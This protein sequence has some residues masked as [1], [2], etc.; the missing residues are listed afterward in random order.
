MFLLRGGSRHQHICDRPRGPVHPPTPP[1]RNSR[2]DAVIVVPKLVDTPFL[3]RI[4]PVRRIGLSSNFMV[5]CKCRCDFSAVPYFKAKGIETKYVAIW[6]AELAMRHRDESSSHSVLRAACGWGL[7]Q[8]YGCLDTR[9]RYFDPE[10]LAR[11]QSGVAVFLDSYRA[12]AVESSAAY[13]TGWHMV[14]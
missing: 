13:T 6:A 14:S 9:V 2:I 3:C 4:Q 7:L 5:A 12:L 8:Y 11:L 1:I 10:T